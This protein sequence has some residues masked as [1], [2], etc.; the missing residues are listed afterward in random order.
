MKSYYLFLFPHYPHVC[1]S[2]AYRLSSL[3]FIAEFVLVLF[4]FFQPTTDTVRDTF[5]IDPA[6]ILMVVGVVMFF[7]TFCGCIGALRENIRLLKI[8]R[9]SA[10]SLLTL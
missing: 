9:L 1:E 8:V 4:Y 5:L 6:V 7:I 10:F 2:A 3:N